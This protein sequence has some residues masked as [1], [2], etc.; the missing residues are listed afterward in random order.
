MTLVAERREVLARH[1]DAMIATGAAA[2]VLPEVAAAAAEQ[3][4]DE[5]AQARLIRTYHAVGQRAKAFQVYR[6]VRDRLVEELGVDP[7]PELRAAH[8]A[9][10]ADDAGPVTE[11]RPALPV[12]RQLPAES[13]GFT[14]RTTQLSTLDALLPETGSGGA[15]TI[16]AI[17]VDRTRQRGGGRARH[18]LTHPEKACARP[19]LSRGGRTFRW[20]VRSGGTRS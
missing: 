2:T 9:L 5:S 7:G 16:A 4:L 3:S 1:G 17:P 12:P 6:D 13:P 15:V 8:A 10:L 20:L 19:G 18:E 14:G 11:T